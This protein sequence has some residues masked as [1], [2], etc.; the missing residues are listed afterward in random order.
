M[1]VL[2]C[3]VLEVSLLLG[4]GCAAQPGPALPPAAPSQSIT[5]R[6][7]GQLLIATLSGDRFFGPD[8]EIA[9]AAQSLRGRAY[10]AVV[11]LRTS[12]SR[13]DGTVGSGRTELHLYVQPEGLALR[14]L[15]ADSLGRLE[16]RADRITGQLG[17]CQYDLRSTGAA[18][19]EYYGA[20]VC[21]GVSEPAELA[22]PL[23]VVSLAP[24]DRAALLAIL[25][26]R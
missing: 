2:A 17:G 20:R 26:G 5:L 25:L 6:T 24:A 14:G 7:P 22:L 23:V 1:R 18:V 21:R 9:R 15:Y 13:I 4:T 19:A 10:G 3:F 16:V 8:I 12:E 11:D